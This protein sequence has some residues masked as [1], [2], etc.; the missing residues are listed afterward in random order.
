[1]KTSRKHAQDKRIQILLEAEAFQEIY[2]RWKNVGYPLSSIVPSYATA[3]GTSAD[4]PD[5]LAELMGIIINN[6]KRYK[7]SAIEK[8]HFAKGTP[9]ETTYSFNSGEP[10]Q[11]ISQDIA[12]TARPLLF[13]VVANGTAIRLKDGIK[14]GNNIYPVGGKT[15]TG[16]HRYQV[17]G[18][19]GG[20]C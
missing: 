8:L 16:D 9:Y 3:L 19:G 20:T 6:G 4:R 10:I 18:K 2:Q 5:A 15:G 1:M 11:A 12:S 17:F 13:D 14:I 7:K